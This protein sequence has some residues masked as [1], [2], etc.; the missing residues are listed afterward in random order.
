MSLNLKIFLKKTP[1][2]IEVRIFYHFF[3]L[4]INAYF[5][6]EFLTTTFGRRTFFQKLFYLTCLNQISIVIYYMMV[7]FY[8]I[9]LYLNGYPKVSVKRCPVFLLTYLKSNLSIACL[10]TCSFWILKTFFPEMLVPKRLE[11]LVL[12]PANLEYWMHGGNFLFLIVDLIW[13]QHKKFLIQGEK[14]FQ[15]FFLVFLSYGVGLIFF[16]LMYQ[17]NVYPFMDYLTF[18]TATLMAVIVIGILIIFDFIFSFVI[19]ELWDDY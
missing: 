6:I 7:L 14:R 17:K 19:Q 2:F 10:V 3:I 15:I 11:G 16:N 1:T 18:V 9:K 5:L 12:V 13:E 8:N 4:L